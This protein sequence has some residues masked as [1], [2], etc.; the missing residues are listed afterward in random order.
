[1]IDLRERPLRITRPAV[2]FQVASGVSAV[3]DKLR[4]VFKLHEAKGGAWLQA[5]FRIASGH[6]T[7]SVPG[8]NGH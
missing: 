6:Y 1:M 2:K 3:L 4:D 8:V 7:V 5:L